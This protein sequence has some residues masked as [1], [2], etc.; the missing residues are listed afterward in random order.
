MDVSMP[1][2]NGLKA[3]RELQRSLPHVKVLTLTRHKDDGYFSSYCAR[4]FQVMS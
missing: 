3:T 1:R 2:L 4:A